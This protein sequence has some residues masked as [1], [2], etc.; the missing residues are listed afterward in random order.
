MVK[1]SKIYM[2]TLLSAALLT[3][4]TKP[5]EK[6][7]TKPPVTDNAEEDNTPVQEPEAEVP[8]EE[9]PEEELHPVT[10][11]GIDYLSVEGI[12][13]EPGTKI[14]MVATSSKSTYW[15]TVKKGASAAIAD[16]NKKLGYSG[17]DKIAF[18][19][20]GPK[21]E[22]VIDQI[23]IIDQFL[24]R[25]PDALCMAFTDATACKTQMEMAKNNGIKLIA[26]DTSDAGRV[27][28]ALV[29]T[30][31]KAAQR[32]A[33]AKMFEA[34]GYEGR[35]A[36]IVHNSASQTGQDRKQAIID[37]LTENYNDKN[38]Q[39]LDI[40]YMEQENRS[41]DEILSE[42]LER[43]PNLAGIICTDGETTEMVL[44]Y[45]KKLENPGFQV[46]GFDV[47]EKIIAE[48][49]GILYGTMAQDPYGIGYATVVAAARS[50][51]EMGNAENIV[52]DHLWVDSS[53]VQSEEVQSLLK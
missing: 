38:I 2:I 13:L 50:I 19:F 21:N 8:P 5:E 39:F 24:D 28:E 40:V 18:V 17:K 26:F 42:L 29:A 23:N 47:S 16:L 20:D 3:G 30:D 22:S 9:E 12:T 53:N 31:N 14:A 52:T 34:I 44:N 10:A 7:D 33:A 49:E 45:A 41:S 6:P 48:T 32:E 1:L 37:E 43:E 4:C 51:A 11:D 35:V 36:I 15:N 27:T 46:V 25:E